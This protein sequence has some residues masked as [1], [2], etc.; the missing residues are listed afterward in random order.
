MKATIEDRD[1][2]AAVSPSALSAYVRAEGWSSVEKF[3]EH[4]DVFVRDKH[5]ELILPGIDTLGDYPDVVS[6]IIR[7]LARSENRDEMQVYKD[8]V[9]ADR[10]VIRVRASE[11]VGPCESKQAW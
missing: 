2:L 3:G 11:A 10:D 6:N 7:L 4:S 9:V 5:P 1:A 8:L